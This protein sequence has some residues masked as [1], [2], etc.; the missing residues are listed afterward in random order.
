MTTIY[1]QI[2]TDTIQ[3]FTTN[4]DGSVTN[5]PIVNGRTRTRLVDDVEEIYSPWDE[6]MATNPT[7]EPIEIPVLT[8]QDYSVSAQS[9]LDT[10]AISMG[11]DSIF[12]AISYEGDA[13]QKFNDEAIALKT[14]RSLVWQNAY[15]LLAQVEAGEVEA[16]TIE[17][18]IA[19]LPAFVV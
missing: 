14:W 2:D 10:Q 11:Y 4:E 7:I 6:L 18:F 19:Q 5:G 15:A 17:E 16:P 8:Q 9:V 3:F 13:F 1:K 12:T